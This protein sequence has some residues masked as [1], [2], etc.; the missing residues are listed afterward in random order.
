MKPIYKKLLRYAGII[1]LITGVI[2]LGQYSTDLPAYIC[3]E[4]LTLLIIVGLI[5]SIGIIAYFHTGAK[6]V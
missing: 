3:I 6:N 5:I 1:A 2:L 4:P